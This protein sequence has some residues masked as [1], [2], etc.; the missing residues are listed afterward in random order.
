[1][2]NEN[3]RNVNVTKQ[4]SPRGNSWGVFCRATKPVD[5]RIT[6]ADSIRLFVNHS[7]T[8]ETPY[9]G[10]PLRDKVE[11]REKERRERGS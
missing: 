4:D 10:R 1:M 11:E 5:K 2:D 7:L 3:C 6:L 8:A 9:K